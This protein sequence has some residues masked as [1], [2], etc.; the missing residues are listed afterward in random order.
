M[1]KLLYIIFAVFSLYAHAQ[2]TDATL[3]TQSQQIKNETT[4]GAN[5]A[6]RVG[7]LFQNL[8]YAKKSFFTDG[9]AGGTDTYTTTLNN[10]AVTALS[11][12]W[13]VV[14]FTNAN[15][16]AA[17]L[18]IN[19]IGAKSLVKTDGTALS[20]GDIDAGSVHL[21]SYDG[22]NLQ[23][24]SIGGSGGGAGTPGGSTTHVQFNDAGAFGGDADFTFTGGNTLNVDFAIV[25]TE[26]YD[27]T[28]WNGDLSVPTKDAL[29][30]K[31]ETITSTVG[32]Q[33][34][35]ISAAAMWPR[36]TS[37]CSA[38]T[39]TEIATS[40]FNIQTLNFDQTTQEYAQFQL[41]LPRKYNNGTITAYVYWTASSGSGTVQWEISGGAYSN[42]DPLTTAFGT[43]VE[44]DDTLIATGDAHITSVS[45]AITF[46]GSPADADFIGIQISRDPSEDTLSGDA[47]LLGIVFKITTDSG[48][49]E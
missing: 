11:S 48:T 16:G 20:S 23:V 22:T 46:S 19:S 30:D 27:A 49:D 7:T 31:I 12:Q 47:K 36:I 1:K 39:Q 32:I 17:T 5:T 13:F 10:G 6:N 24:L 8:T 25:D 41:V 42:D 26:A 45:S 9:T 4:T 40:L 33:D 3:T 18:N 29:R 15:T 21:I 35:F 28:G 44:I 34:L 2:E 14:K 37:P 43:E 38:L